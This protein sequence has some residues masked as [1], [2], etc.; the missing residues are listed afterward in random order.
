VGNVWVAL[1]LTILAGLAAAIGSGIAFVA[2]RTDCRFLSVSTGFSAGVLVYVSLVDLLD[3]VFSRLGALYGQPRG[4]GSPSL[5]S[6][7]ASRSALSL[8]I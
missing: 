8:I 2:K 7:A 6:S 1:E 3:Q 4:R 5:R